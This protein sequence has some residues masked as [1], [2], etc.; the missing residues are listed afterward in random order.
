MSRV[1]VVAPGVA[2][3]PHPLLP[4]ALERDDPI[5]DVVVDVVEVVVLDAL[6]PHAPSASAPTTATPP[7]KSRRVT[8]FASRG[9]RRRLRPGTVMVS[10]ARWVSSV[11]GGRS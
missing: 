10:W 11:A 1:K 7:A 5:D 3:G 4:P 9:R 6:P 2:A 8:L